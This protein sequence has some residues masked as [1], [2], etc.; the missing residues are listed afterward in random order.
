M[1]AVRGGELMAGS[2][3]VL[4][5]IFLLDDDGVEMPGDLNSGARAWP[6]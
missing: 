2:T 6:N 3:G 5:S 4:K 1:S